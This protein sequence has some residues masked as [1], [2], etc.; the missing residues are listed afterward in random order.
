MD[1]VSEMVR[2]ILT[3]Y[4]LKVIAAI[5]ILIIGRLVSGWIRGLLHKMMERGGTDPM[6]ISFVSNLAY[7]ALLAFVVIAAI[8]QVGI[9]T[10]SFI[11]VLGAAGLAIGL[12]LQ[13]SLQNFA[14]GVLII[15]YRPYKVGDFVE[16]GGTAGIIE[17]MDI[18]TTRMR[19]GDNKAVIVPNSKLLGDNITNYSAKPTRRLDLVIGVGYGDDL[20]RVKAVLN[21][22]LT[23]DPRVLQDPAPTIG[24]VAL[25]D[26]SVDFA[27]RPWV[28]S[29]DYWP[30]HF[31]LLETIKNRFD[32]EGISI[33]YPQRDVHLHSA[34]PEGAG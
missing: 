3:V 19:T 7:F 11:A 6:L 13:G 15:I 30:L 2:E 23:A 33:P 25:G 1:N 24:V 29:G 8:N 20:A 22:I 26:N 4:G 34:T 27:V 9:Q 17:E 14:A 32:A 16:G 28:D 21:D 5:A 18:F 10:T 12:A 31:D